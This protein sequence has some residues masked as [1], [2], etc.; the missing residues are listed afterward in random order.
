MSDFKKND[1][2][3]LQWSLMPFEQLEDV[4]RVLMKGAEKYGNDNWKH[5]DDINRYKDALMRHVTS[6]IKGEQDDLEDNL[7][8]LAHAMCNCLFLMYFDTRTQKGIEEY[9]RTHPELVEDSKGQ[10]LV[11][12]GR[13]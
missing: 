4:V 11:Y 9:L 1:K 5:C 2:G 8:H 12:V 3:K 10:E 7:P 6:Y 13:K